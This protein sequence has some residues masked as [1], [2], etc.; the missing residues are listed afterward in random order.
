MSIV[1]VDVLLQDVSADTPSGPNLEYDPAFLELEQSAVGKPEVQYGTTITPAVPPDWKIVKK[2]AIDLLKRSHDLRVAMPLVRALLG[3]HAMPGFA[4][5]LLILTGLVESRW[6]SVHPELDPDDDND[7]TLRINSLGQLNDAASI[8]RDLRD[9]PFVMLPNLG[10]LSLRVIE[11]STGETPMPAGQ[12]ALAPD[13]IQ[14]ALRDVSPEAMASAHAAVS[15]VVASVA[16][17]EETL[18]RQVGSA[19]ALNLSPIK[20]LLKRMSD[21]LAPFVPQEIVEEEAPAEEAADAVAGDAPAAAK[22]AAAPAHE[23]NSA[24]DVVRTIDRI[25]AY[26]ARVEPSSPVP[27][28]LERAKRLATMNFLEVMQNLAPDSLAQL[29]AI[30][31]PQPE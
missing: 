28:L 19:N 6:S 30:R 4:D 9:T 5:G 27:M 2:Q 26:Y 15:S 16:K 8:L 18:E 21:T 10:P 22:R 31:G 12:K 7:P 24:A 14:A 17:V 20:R 23:L 29:T 11:Q 25:L 3:L 1:D 13:S